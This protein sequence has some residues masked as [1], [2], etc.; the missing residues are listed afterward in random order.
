[1]RTSKANKDFRSVRMKLS[2]E[3]FAVHP[4]EPEQMPSDLV[5]EEVWNEITWLTDD[6]S[7][8]GNPRRIAPQLTCQLLGQLAI[9]EPRTE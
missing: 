4:D 6:V 5:G 3:S 8:I 1:M 2:P 9:E 7:L